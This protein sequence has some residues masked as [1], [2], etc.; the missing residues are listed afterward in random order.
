MYSRLCAVVDVLSVLLLILLAVALVLLA[1]AFF[2]DWNDR[3]DQA[4]ARRSKRVRI[5]NWLTNFDFELILTNYTEYNL[6]VS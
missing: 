2:N 4:L 6:P 5:Q 3:V 1:L